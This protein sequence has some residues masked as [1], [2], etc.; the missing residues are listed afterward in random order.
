[1]RGAAL[2][3]GGATKRKMQE[4]L[5]SADVTDRQTGRQ[6]ARGWVTERIQDSQ[7]GGNVRQ[8]RERMPVE[9]GKHVKRL[10]VIRH[11]GD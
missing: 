9:G 5:S 4:C 6:A 11:W 3:L 8:T 7:A 2:L 1:M 10:L